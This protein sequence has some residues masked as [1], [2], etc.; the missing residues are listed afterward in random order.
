MYD[1]FIKSYNLRL[2]SVTI[3]ISEYYGLFCLIVD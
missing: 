3:L 2:F 1:R